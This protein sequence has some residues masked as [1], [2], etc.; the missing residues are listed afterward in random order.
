MRL[1]NNNKF[2]LNFEPSINAKLIKQFLF[3][4]NDGILVTHREASNFPLTLGKLHKL[5][6][7]INM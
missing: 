4:S 1:G 2:Q 5:A 6:P 7:Y 3:T